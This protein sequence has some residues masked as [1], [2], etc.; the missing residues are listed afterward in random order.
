MAALRV[1]LQAEVDAPRSLV[2]PLMSTAAGLARWLDAAAMEPRVGAGV[3]LRLRDA[4]AVGTVLAVDAPQHISWS[5]DWEGQPLGASTVL[6]LDVIDH[7][8]RSHV[9]LRHVG[10]RSESQWQDHEALWSYWFG[11][12]REA[13]LRAA[14]DGAAGTDA[15]CQPRRR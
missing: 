13:V 11:R 7:G 8:D 9:T 1:E 5:W 3:R 2:F 6:A 12:F 14:D 10:F 4:V 15:R